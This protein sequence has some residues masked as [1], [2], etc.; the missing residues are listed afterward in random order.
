MPMPDLINLGLGE[1]DFAPPK[2]VIDAAKKA[3]ECGKTHYT[4]TNGIPELRKALARKANIEYGLAHDC[5][6][7]I[8]VAVGGTE[9][10]FLA[11]I[12]LINPGDEVLIPNPGFVCYEPSVLLA[13]GVPVYF[14]LLE[15]NEF[16][17]TV[18]AVTSLITDK[19]RV[20]LLNYPNNPTSTVLSCGEFAALVTA[21]VERDL[22]VISDEVYERITYDNAKHF[23][24]ATFPKMLERTLVVNSF[25]KAYAMTGL[26]VGYV[27]GPKKLVSIVC[28]LTSLLSHA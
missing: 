17:P 27:Y 28:L 2:H 12:G 10:I 21:A 6:S 19:S 16:K 20:I 14:P 23:C 4:Q 26:R 11:L 8:L 9:A 25:S 5:E 3:A 18:D 22:I 13:G 7:E 24:L 1:P 15:E